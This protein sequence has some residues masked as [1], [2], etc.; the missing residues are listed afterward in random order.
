MPVSVERYATTM[1]PNPRQSL[2]LLPAAIALALTAAPA[3]AQDRPVPYWA[4]IRVDEVNMRVG[5]AETYA[6]AWVFHRKQ[7][8]MKVVRLKEGWRLVQDPEGAQGWMLARFLSP[9][10]SA[11][12][13]AGEPV[14][15]REE[16][17]ANARLRWRLAPGVVGK[18]GDCESGWCKL[19]VAGRTGFVMQSRLWGAGEP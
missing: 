13:T 19:D 15:M 10:R 11:I 4:S 7:L 6:I 5:P 2:A 1:I 8:P 12:V 16:P 14:D 9:E 18:L 3:S 17:A